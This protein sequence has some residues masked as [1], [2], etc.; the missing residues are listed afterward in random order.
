MRI[1]PI[2]RIQKSNFL[3]VKNIL[4]ELMCGTQRAI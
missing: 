2:E 4:V 3:N 1:E